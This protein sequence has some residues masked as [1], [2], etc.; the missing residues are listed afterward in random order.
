MKEKQHVCGD[1][2]GYDDDH[3]F[4]LNGCIIKQ[5]DKLAK[6]H[7]CKQRICYRHPK[8][9]DNISHFFCRSCAEDN[10]FVVGTCIFHFSSLHCRFP[11]SSEITCDL[12]SF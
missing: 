11:L 2:D 9:C 5:L 4:Y 8:F 6:C 12:C 1:N 7:L 10:S 3:D